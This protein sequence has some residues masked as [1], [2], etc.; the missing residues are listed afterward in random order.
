MKSAISFLGEPFLS[1]TNNENTGK[2]SDPSGNAL[3][4]KDSV[5]DFS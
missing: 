2:Q 3:G 5:S 1:L 4:M